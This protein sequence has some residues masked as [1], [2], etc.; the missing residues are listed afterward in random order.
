MKL[1]KVNA[2]VIIWSDNEVLYNK[3][4]YPEC[5]EYDRYYTLISF[6]GCRPVAPGLNEL[7]WTTKF[8]HH[9]FFYRQIR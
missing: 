3:F 5:G 8:H 1:R 9:S 2:C 7:R 4:K 6:F